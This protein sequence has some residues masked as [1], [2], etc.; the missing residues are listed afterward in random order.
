M[1]SSLTRLV[2]YDG[3]HLV[4][5]GPN[6]F[7][8]DWLAEHHRDKIEHAA[9]EILGEEST[10]EFI[11]AAAPARSEAPA[12]TA[13]RTIMVSDPV[14]IPSGCHLNARYVFDEFVVGSS[15]RFAHAAA[16][17][18][19]EQPAQRLQPAL[20][21]RRRRPRQDASPPGDRTPRHRAAPAAAGRLRLRRGVHE[22]ADPRH[23]LRIDARRSRSAIAT[24][25]CS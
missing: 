17:A 19:A 13:T 6:S 1:V 12:Q 25:T 15:N 18:V 5:E 9:R 20:H 16:H 22:R 24:S 14:S 21:L 11:A 2:A 7:F 4:V 8:F 10:V 3:G 23:P